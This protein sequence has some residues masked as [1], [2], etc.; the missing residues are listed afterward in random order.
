MSLDTGR[1]TSQST[2]APT[3]MRAATQKSGSGPIGVIGP[4]LAVLLLALGALLLRDALVAAGAFQGRQWLPSAVDALDGFAPV[5]W[6]IPAGIV[7][8]LIG[9]WLVITALRPRSR[10]TLP[11]ASRSGVFLHTRDVARLASSAA[12]A[13]DGVLS[14]SST[15]TRKRVTVAVQATA[16]TGLRESV[17]S[18]V[19]ER[20]SALQSPPRVNVTMR[21]PKEN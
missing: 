9:L 10:K 6:V 19:T 21:T 11:L 7:V 18:A 14:A 15:A 1:D 16:E 8:A 17:T 12:S 3:P 5:R 2:S 13:V 4:L 20:L